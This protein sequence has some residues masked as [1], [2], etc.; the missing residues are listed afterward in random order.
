MLYANIYAT[1]VEVYLESGRHA[2]DGQASVQALEEYEQAHVYARLGLALVQR[3]QQ[4]SE[5]LTI[6]YLNAGDAFAAMG[7][8]LAGKRHA[9][10]LE[11][12]GC[13]ELALDITESS[14]LPA[15]AS[16]ARRRLQV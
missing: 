7:M 16:E 12:R 1:A 6:A 15:L 11:A 9:Y 13:W 8:A 5:M 10:E 3:V 4:Q 14:A 2:P